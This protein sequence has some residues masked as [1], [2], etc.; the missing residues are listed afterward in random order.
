VRL[1]PAFG[2][3]AL[4]AV[5]AFGPA[6]ASLFGAT[7]GAGPAASLSAASLSASP[8]RV[9]VAAGGHSTLRVTNAGARAV[10]VTAGPAGYALDL[11]GRPRIVRSGVPG[12]SAPWL[13]VRPR[14]FRLAPGATIPLTIATALPRHASPGDHA[15]LIVLATRPADVGRVAVALRLGVVVDVRV[16]GVVVRRLSLGAARVRRFAGSRT[17]EVV[18]ANRGNVSE[19]LR[20]GRVKVTLRRRGRL[21]AVL[22]S[23]GQEL[24]PHTTA[25]VEL[26]YRGN[27]HGRVTAVVELSQ[28]VGRA[29][30]QRRFEV[31]L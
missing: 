17:L 29:S 9:R 21:L 8:S 15:A 5:L 23:R 6:P 14:R 1:R 30:V 20:A 7:V 25:I 24:L 28:A 26:R 27:V 4:S 13:V 2:A 3:A 16:P 10:V 19:L 18:V 31:R 11:R 12:G 22:R